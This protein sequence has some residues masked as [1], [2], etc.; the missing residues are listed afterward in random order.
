MEELDKQGI[1]IQNFWT[2]GRYDAISIT[3]APTEKDVMIMMIPY[4]D[5]M[6]TETLTAV[7]Q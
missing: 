5:V 3:E 4:Q 7:P 2:L 6:T 1:K